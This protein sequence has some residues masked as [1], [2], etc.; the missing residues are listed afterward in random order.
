MILD[1]KPSAAVTASSINE[2]ANGSDFYLHFWDLLY[3]ELDFTFLL[4]L[5]VSMEEGGEKDSR[6]DLV[7][8]H[9]PVIRREWL[10]EPLVSPRVTNGNFATAFTDHFCKP[11]HTLSLALRSGVRAGQ[12]RNP[13]FSWNQVIHFLDN[14]HQEVDAKDGNKI[15]SLIERFRDK[16]GSFRH[17]FRF[18]QHDQD[19]NPP[20]GHQ[21]TATILGWMNIASTVYFFWCLGWM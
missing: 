7:K 3:P 2:G 8:E 13:F 11:N 16:K 17:L 15:I 18:G 10:L 1:L 14:I 21:K 5:L 4:S 19:L 6:I 9:N 12:W 20:V